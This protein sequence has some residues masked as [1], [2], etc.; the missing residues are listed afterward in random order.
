[1]EQV[2]MT[3]DYGKRLLKGLVDQ[4]LHRLETPAIAAE[5]SASEM[6]LIR[7]LC[8]DNSVSLASIKA[9]DFGETAQRVAEEFPFPE[10][11]VVDMSTD[12]SH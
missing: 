3:D 6:E 10:G 2:T 1:M 11:G 9:G 8:S 12:T 5:M 7:K 4:L